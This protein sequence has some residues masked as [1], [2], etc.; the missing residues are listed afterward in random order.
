M[1]DIIERMKFILMGEKALTTAERHALPK[2]AFVYPDKEGY[3][4]HDRRHAANALA[5]VSQFGTP[6]EKT[7]VRKTVC[8]KYPDLPYCT[9]NA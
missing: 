2:K 5:R 9:K 7:K 1:T 3:P 4:I 8:K 6:A